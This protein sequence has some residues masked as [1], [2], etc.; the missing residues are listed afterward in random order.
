MSHYANAYTH[1]A[2][3][4]HLRS[5]FADMSTR[6]YT[7]KHRVEDESARKKIHGATFFFSLEQNVHLTSRGTNEKKTLKKTDPT[8]KKAFPAEKPQYYIV[9]VIEAYPRQDWRAIFGQVEAT[10]LR[11]VCYLRKLCKRLKIPHTK[12]N[13]SGIRVN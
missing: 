7:N 11:I 6:M 5:S 1:H 13:Q 12:W 3:Y 8:G 9:F 2:V 10:V 4:L